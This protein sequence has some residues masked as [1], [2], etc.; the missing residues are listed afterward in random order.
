MIIFRI[1]NAAFK[2][3]LSGTG[4]SIYGGR[5]NSK[6]N[7]ALYTASHISLALLELVVNFNASDSP[8]LPDYHLIHIDIPTDNLIS[9]K[10]ED[11]KPD[12]QKDLS[13][14]RFIG[15]EFLGENKSLLL[16]IPSA[17]VPEE[18]NYLIN[19][20]HKLFRSIRII[21]SKSYVVDRRLI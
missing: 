19:P 1:V 20:A 10:A 13:Y 8:L 12:W 15:D 17:V 5:W 7:K 6:G 11:L 18:C 21:H 4:A 9:I 3:D 16:K 14:T 2:D